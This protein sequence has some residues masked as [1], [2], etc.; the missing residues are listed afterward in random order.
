MYARQ[1]ATYRRITTSSQRNFVVRTLSNAKPGYDRV[2]RRC[3]RADG[4]P[5]R[6][7]RS[8]L[9]P[10]SRATA[11]VAVTCSGVARPSSAR[12]VSQSRSPYQLPISLAHPGLSLTIT[13]SSGTAS[14][15]C[16][17]SATR[18][19]ALDVPH[20]PD[21]AHRS[22]RA[23]TRA[24]TSGRGPSARDLRRR[25]HDQQ[26]RRAAA[27]SGRPI[28]GCARPPTRSSTRSGIAIDGPDEEH[29]LARGA[30]TEEPERGDRRRAQ[31]P[32]HRRDAN[33][34]KPPDQCRPRR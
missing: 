12:A 9:A 20:H 14:T 7:H 28:A 2:R 6:S 19:R 29:L 16:A 34:A 4:R 22:R 1:T 17:N 10:A 30:L 27:G 31:E 23:P 13:M 32:G 15:C 26:R 18:S 8:R 24:T 21:D 5:S 33:G 11:T 3:D 25:E